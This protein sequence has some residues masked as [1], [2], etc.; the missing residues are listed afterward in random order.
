MK[1]NQEFTPGPTDIHGNG[2]VISRH[3]YKKT[4]RDYT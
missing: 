3:N 2:I 1:K 4:F